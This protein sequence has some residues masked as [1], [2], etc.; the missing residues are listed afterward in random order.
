MNDK[1]ISDS[2]RK[3]LINLRKEVESKVLEYGRQTYFINQIEETL[4][5]EKEKAKE[6]K[7][8]ISDIKDQKQS[9]AQKLYKKYGDVAID[10]DSGD[11]ISPED[12]S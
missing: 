11:I 9:F 3:R 7:S 1:K 5:Q 10:I 6:L 12:A 8:E 2:E 4:S